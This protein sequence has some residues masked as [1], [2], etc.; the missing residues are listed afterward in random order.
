MIPLS[1]LY[2]SLGRQKRVSGYLDLLGVSYFIVHLGG[3]VTRF[4]LVS[5]PFSSRL[6]GW[7]FV[8]TSLSRGS[9][10]LI[11]S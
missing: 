11:L 4:S 8:L 5:D 6:D 2:L 7:G 10:Y 1:C 9:G 3:Q